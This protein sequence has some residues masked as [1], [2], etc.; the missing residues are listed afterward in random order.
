MLAYYSEELRALATGMIN[1]NPNERPSVHEVSSGFRLRYHGSRNA[2]H[3]VTVC[4]LRTSVRVSLRQYQ[5]LRMGTCRH[6]EDCVQEF[7]ERCCM[8][9]EGLFI[10]LFYDTARKISKPP[11]MG[12]NRSQ[13]PHLSVAQAVVPKPKRNRKKKLTPRIKACPFSMSCNTEI[14]DLFKVRSFR[15]GPCLTCFH[16]MCQDFDSREKLQTTLPLLHIL[17][18]RMEQQKSLNTVR[19]MQ[20]NQTTLLQGRAKGRGIRMEFPSTH[21][22]ILAR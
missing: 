4:D 3:S 7:T 6:D 20:G 2:S 12:T 22:C 18:T 5:S 9:Y 21:P 17:P 16:P 15:N 14:Y 13:G 10:E 19:L 11:S 1:T 8:L